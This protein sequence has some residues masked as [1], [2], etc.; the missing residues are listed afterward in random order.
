MRCLSAVVLALLVSRVGAE[1]D[2]SQPYIVVEPK[3]KIECDDGSIQPLMH[4]TIVWVRREEG[5][6]VFVTPREHRPGWVAKDALQ[7]EKDALSWCSEKIAADA[8]AV[9]YQRRC[10]TQLYGSSRDSAKALEDAEKAVSLDP[11]GESYYV[12]G[13]VWYFLGD[14]AKATSDFSDAIRRDPKLVGA[15]AFRA[16]G[17]LAQGEDDQALSDVEEALRLEMSSPLLQLRG[18]IHGASGRTSKA[19]EDFDA[20]I[21]LNPFDA[22]YFMF[23]GGAKY[24]QGNDDDAKQDF[25]QALRLNPKSLYALQARGLIHNAQGNYD[26]AISDLSR[27]LELKP[28]EF[29]VLAARATVYQKQGK[30]EQASEDL[31]AIIRLRPDDGYS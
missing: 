27:A 4:G 12:R 30:Y 29:E 6:R 15:Y 7:L 20:A 11:S 1:F 8:S 24:Q 17:Y 26:N 31:G 18:Q 16:Y 3:I 9:N 28:D 10:I 19:I 22:N 25:D 23:R 2:A 21:R 14:Q 13:V 5:D